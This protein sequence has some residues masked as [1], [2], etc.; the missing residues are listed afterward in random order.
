MVAPPIGLALQFIV[1]SEPLRKH[2]FTSTP[3]LRNLARVVKCKISFSASSQ[4]ESPSEDLNPVPCRPRIVGNAQ[5]QN[6]SEL[7]H[8]A[9]DGPLGFKN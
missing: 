7:T 9:T 6:A 1:D 3:G 8:Y 4:A 5:A 2:E